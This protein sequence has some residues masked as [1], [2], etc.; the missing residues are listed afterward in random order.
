[1]KFLVSTFMALAVMLSCR[2][3]QTTDPFLIEV[4]MSDSATTFTDGRVADGSYG[5]ELLLDSI[6]SLES[7]IDDSERFAGVRY[8]GRVVVQVLSDVP[9]VRLSNMVHEVGSRQFNECRFVWR[10]T[11]GEPAVAIPIIMRQDYGVTHCIEIGAAGMTF[12]TREQAVLNPPPDEPFDAR[13]KPYSLEMTNIPGARTGGWI[14]QQTQAD[15]ST[16]RKR[17][18]Q[19]LLKEPSIQEVFFGQPRYKGPPSSRQLFFPRTAGNLDYA[20]LSELLTRLNEAYEKVGYRGGR[21]YEIAVADSIPSSEFLTV[22][23][24]IIESV[25]KEIQQASWFDLAL[26]PPPPSP[27]SGTYRYYNGLVCSFSEFSIH[28]LG[29]REMRTDRDSLTYFDLTNPAGCLV[30]AIEDKDLPLIDRLV[31]KLPTHPFKRLTN[32][33]KPFSGYT[34]LLLA[35]ELEISE[36][37]GHLIQSGADVDMSADDGAVRPLKLAIQKNNQEI[38]RILREAGAQ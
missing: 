27:P 34:P 13:R 7:A 4:N 16:R 19:S 38:V 17:T 36:V 26:P 10:E 32:V 33:A 12:S 20:S 6:A 14:K 37:V 9:C 1:M 15:T 35:I 31:P 25:P 24:A 30:G 8:P 5:A 29:L 2:S 28:L 3:R 11:T 18:L 23:K 22:A 21:H